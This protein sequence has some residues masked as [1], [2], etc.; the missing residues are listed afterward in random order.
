MDD[1]FQHMEEWTFK[2]PRLAHTFD[3]HVREQLPW[4]DMVLKMTA[5]LVRHYLP[6]GGRMYNIGA[7]TGNLAKE[8]EDVLRI[9]KAEL[10]SIDNSK[11][12]LA[13]HPEIGNIET[14]EAEDFRYKKFDAAVC[15]LVLMFINKEKRIKL[16]NKLVKKCRIGGIIIVVERFEQDLGYISTAVTRYIMSQ[17]LTGGV[18][19]EDIVKKEL[20]LSGV[21]R[22]L[23]QYEMPRN[24]KEFFRIGDFIGYVIEKTA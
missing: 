14:A 5:H 8:L 2:D 17:K 16:L 12:M 15:Y 9:R 6:K 10:V 20:L 1:I 7:S 18:S 3:R 22:P 13:L 21:Q 23:S 4:Y 24:A 19:C 11:E